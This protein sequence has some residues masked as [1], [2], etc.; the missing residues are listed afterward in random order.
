MDLT[1]IFTA[2][3]VGIPLI[4]LVFGLVE[5]M[6]RLKNKDGEQAISGNWPLIVSLLWGLLLGGL[7]MIAQTRPPAGDWWTV[8]VYWFGVVV[9]GLALGFL[10]SLFYDV[11]KALVDKLIQKQLSSIVERLETK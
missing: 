9:Y 6:K 11:L 3:I 5:F 2:S 4:F 10:A 8:Y 7:Y 1:K